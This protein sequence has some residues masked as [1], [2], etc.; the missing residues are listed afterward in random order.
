MARLGSSGRFTGIVGAYQ[1]IS[2][3]EGRPAD[4]VVALLA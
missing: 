1:R 4:N 3:I 2:L